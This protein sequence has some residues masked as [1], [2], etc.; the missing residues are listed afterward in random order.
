MTDNPVSPKQPGALA[1]IRVIDLSRILGGPYCGQILGDHGADVLKVEPPQ[2]DN[3]RAAVVS[4]G[5]SELARL[6]T[7]GNGVSGLLNGMPVVFPS[8]DRICDLR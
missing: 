8:R 5:L 3:T 1:G 6:G 2:G 7:I 4:R